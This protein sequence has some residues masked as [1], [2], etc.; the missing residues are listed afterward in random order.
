MSRNRHADQMLY[1]E[2]CGISFL[3]T[4]EEQRQDWEGE[5]PPTPVLC[6]PGCRQLLPAEHRERGL[7]KWY[8]HR[9]H[10]GFLTRSGEPD[11][12]VHRSA[13]RD[14][15]RLNPGDLVEFTV[16][17]GERGPLAT[18]V[19]RLSRSA[20]SSTASSANTA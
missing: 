17:E 13:L 5:T 18:E 1:C 4:T 15:A 10:Y 9:K 16:A 6:C 19:M 8:N 20:Q 7:V 14:S 12:F 3:W 11:I 2:R